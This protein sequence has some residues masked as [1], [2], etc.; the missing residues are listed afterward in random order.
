[1]RPPSQGKAKGFCPEFLKGEEGETRD[2]AKER[3]RVSRAICDV[4]L[5]GML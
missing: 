3:R 4:V 5:Y 2:E 1:M